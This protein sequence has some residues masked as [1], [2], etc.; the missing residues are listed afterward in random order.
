MNFKTYFR[1]AH[2]ELKERFDTTADTQFRANFVQKIS[3]NVIEYSNA[4]LLSFPPPENN[5][6][7]LPI[8]S[9]SFA[10]HNQRMQYSI[11]LIFM[12]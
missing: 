12:R 11:A 5:I 4:T 2:K 9:P 3:N 10:Q 6:I 1:R 8:G 7:P